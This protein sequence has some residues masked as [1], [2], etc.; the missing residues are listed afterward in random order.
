M[1]KAIATI[2]AR[3]SRDRVSVRHERRTLPESGVR[4]YYGTFSSRDLEKSLESG[5]AVDAAIDNLP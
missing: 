3:S 4:P 5:V 2:H 1:A